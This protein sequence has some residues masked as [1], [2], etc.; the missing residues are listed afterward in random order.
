MKPL[1]LFDEKSGSGLIEAIKT[2]DGI[3]TDGRDV[4]YLANFGL[5]GSWIVAND[6]KVVW[7]F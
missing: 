1:R 6:S 2:S 3:L 5:E 4:K 7:G